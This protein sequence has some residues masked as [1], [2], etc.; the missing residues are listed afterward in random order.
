MFLTRLSPEK[1]VGDAFTGIAFLRNA[2]SIGIPF[3]ISPW[4]ERDGISN[5]FIACGFISLGITSLVIPMV[6]WGKASRRKLAPLYRKMGRK[7]L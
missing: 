5:M 2:I 4:M 3:A 1:I 7:E 6:V